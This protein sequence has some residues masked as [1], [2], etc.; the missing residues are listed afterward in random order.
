M[1]KQMMQTGRLPA[2]SLDEALFQA[3]WEQW[4]AQGEFL[5][6][7][8][9]GVGGDLLGKQEERPQECPT[10]WQE[11][12]QRLAALPRI[13]SLHLLAEFPERGTVSVRFTNHP[14]VSGQ[15]AVSGDNAEWRQMM[16]AAMQ[17][18]FQAQRDP[19]ANR[20]YNRLVFG[21]IQTAIPLSASFVLVMALAGLLI[22]SYIRHSQWLWW[23]TAGTIVV[24]LRLA[25]SM[26]DYFIKKVLLD[27]PYLRWRS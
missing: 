13:D 9:I 3:L 1:S 25:Y 4:T 7:A 19:K 22:P 2:C 12:Q 18:L 10:D 15:L 27:Y 21:T 24:T 14:P 26:S 23:I 5:W 6:R 17:T 16:Y 8:E 11:L 20:F